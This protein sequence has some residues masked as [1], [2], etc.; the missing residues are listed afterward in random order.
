MRIVIVTIDIPEANRITEAVVRANDNVVGMIASSAIVPGKS[1]IAAVRYL[2][3]RT[4]VKFLLHRVLEKQICWLAGAARRLRF[5]T[6]LVYSLRQIVSRHRIPF[7]R[8]FR[9]DEGVLEKIRSWNPDLV[10]SIY[11]NQIIRSPLLE[12]PQLGCINVHPSLLPRNRGLLPTFWT[13]ANGDYEAGVSIHHVDAGLDTGDVLALRRVKILPTET[14]FSLAHRCCA[15][16]ADLLCETIAEL[17]AGTA[18]SRGQSVEGTCYHSWPDRPSIRRL[19]NL[20]RGLG[21]AGAM[22]WT[23]YHGINEPTTGNHQF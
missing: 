23:F 6:P 2:A 11:F 3:Q 8:A 21:P 19:Y 22:W 15:A 20:G 4:G 7:H 12:I 13:L 14:S 9:V 10:V 5:R 17:Q 16:G 1:N 18:T